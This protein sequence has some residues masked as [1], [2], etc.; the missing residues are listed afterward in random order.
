MVSLFDGGLPDLIVEFKIFALFP[1][2][3]GEFAVGSESRIADSFVDHSQLYLL[4]GNCYQI[5]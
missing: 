2:G 4:N 5:N 3:I 1:G